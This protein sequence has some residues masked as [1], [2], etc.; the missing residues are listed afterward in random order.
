MKN[1]ALAV[2]RRRSAPI[3]DPT[4]IATL[5]LLL[6]PL[7][8]REGVGEESD[9]VGVGGGA[10]EFVV[11]EG[12]GGK[13]VGVDAAEARGVGVAEV[14]DVVV[15][16]VLVADVVGLIM[17]FDAALD[18]AVPPSSG[19]SV[20]NKGFCPLYTTRLKSL[21]MNMSGV[22]LEVPRSDTLKWHTQVFPSSRE[23]RAEPVAGIDWL[24]AGR[25]C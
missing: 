7:D 18:A 13:V 20:H 21:L 10:L 5:L 12:E 8:G 3:V 23:T 11:E 2:T 15:F 25:P 9:G 22:A 1:A 16:D 19:G 6:R 17:G 4:V 14:G 24:Y